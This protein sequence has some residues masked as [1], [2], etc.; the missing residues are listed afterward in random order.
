VLITLF[1]EEGD[2][3]VMV[4]CADPLRLASAADTAVTVTVRVEDT[5][6]GAV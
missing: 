3:A 1:D 4:T 5:D 2:P 6:E